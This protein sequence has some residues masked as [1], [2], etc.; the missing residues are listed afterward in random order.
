MVDEMGGAYS[1]LGRDDNTHK[2]GDVYPEA[3]MGYLR[4]RG[5]IIVTCTKE[6][7]MRVRTESKW[8]SIGSSSDLL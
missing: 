5:K 4:T 2:T 8:L 3:K 7:G 1:M 6:R